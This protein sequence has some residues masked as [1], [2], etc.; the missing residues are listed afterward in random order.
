MKMRI[1]VLIIIFVLLLA[2]LVYLIADQYVVTKSE[3]T[4]ENEK[5]KDEIKIAVIS[6]LHNTNLFN[7][8][9]VVV[10][11][12]KEGKPDLIAVVGDMIDEKKESCE[13]VLNVIKPLP[14]I[15][16]TYYSIGNHDKLYSNYDTY[17]AELK[18]AGVVILD[19]EIENLTING[20]K[21]TIL[22]LTA[23]SN[24]EVEN[25]AYT[26]LLKEFCENDNLKIML[27]HYPEYSHWFF[28]KDLYYEYDFDFM[29]SGHT[30]GGLVRIPFLGGVY[31]PEQGYFAEYTKG[32]YY[33][34]KENKNP[35]HMLVTAGLGEDQRFIRVNNFPEVAFLTVK[36]V[37][38][39]Y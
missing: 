4:V 22:G 10:D 32:L 8:N 9:K 27:C 11:M 18:N 35:Y 2:L 19:D 13:N 34:D 6:D 29:L 33:V 38:E 30:H 21:T 14:E 20:N 25:P 26:A 7:D 1:I 39:W 37:K 31:A 5:V 24:G 36:P 15:A 17:K 12:I 28:G 3:Y 16:P 23:Y